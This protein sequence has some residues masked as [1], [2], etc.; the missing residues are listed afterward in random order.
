VVSAHNIAGITIAAV[1]RFPDFLIALLIA[2]NSKKNV[3]W[4]GRSWSNRCFAIE[5]EVLQ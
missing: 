2:R 4:L 1:S 5:A 3:I